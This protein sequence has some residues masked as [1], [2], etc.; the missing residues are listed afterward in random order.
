MD[1]IVNLEQLFHRSKKRIKDL[2]EVFTPDRYVEDMLDLLAKGNK[3]FWK[4]ENN[5]FFEPCC[6]HGNIVLAIYRRRL[7]AL[8]TKVLSQNNK[9]AAFYA[10]ANSLNTIWAIDIDIEN[11]EST[12]T[13]V[14]HYTLEFMKQKLSY[15]SSIRLI[16]DHE[17]FFTHIF[18]AIKWH[19]YENETLSALSSDDNSYKN[20]NLTRSGSR[21]YSRHDHSPMH[22]DQTWV[23]FFENCE[24]NGLSSLEY[25]KSCKFLKSILH[26]RAPISCEFKFALY[27]FKL[28]I[29]EAKELL[30]A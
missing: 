5:V 8:Y 23:D 1:N 4:N 16:E 14:L 2:G 15:D 24:A 20:A 11:I 9:E 21:W 6:G 19:I 22:F 27:L 10:V 30:G 3:S 25:E 28:N 13:R 7:D 29:M 12:R 17:E 18:A 26:G